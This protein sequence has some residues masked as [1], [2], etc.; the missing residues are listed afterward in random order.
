MWIIEVVPIKKGLPQE[1]LTYFS[2]ER[3]ADGSVVS[4]P[5]RTKNVDAIVLASRDAREEKSAIKS[6]EFS[7]KKITKV[8]E[9]S[10][11]PQSLF[12]TARLAS[13][14]YRVTKGTILDLLI[15]DYSYYGIFPHEDKSKHSTEEIPVQ[16]ER[17]LFQA[18]LDDRISFYRTFIRESFA[19]KES[20]TIVCPTIADCELFSETL[21]KGIADFVTTIHSDIPKK[22]LISTL[23]LLS[24]DTHSFVIICTPSFAS[25]MRSDTTTI[26]LE[27]ESSTAYNTPSVPSY[28]FRVLIEVF[29]RTSGKKFILSDS[30]LRVETLGRHEAHEFTTI[31]P[32]TFRA[33]APIEIDIVPHGIPD[34]LPVRARSEQIP[35]FSNQIRSLISEVVKNK[36]K[37]FAFSLRTGL[38]TVTRCR[39]CG[40]VLHC[41]HCSTP[42][43]LY[44]G[45]KNRVFICNKCKLHTP[46]EQKCTRCASWN[47][48]P[49]GTGTAFV[50]EEIKRLFPEIPV[51]RID[52][53]SAPTKAE[54]RK[55]ASQFKSAS[56]GVLVGT[57]MALFYVSEDITDSVIVSFDTL[58]NIPSYRTN[59][60]IVELF[61][62]IAE[63]TRGRLFVQTKNPDEPI[64]DLVKS[65]NY[66]SW[67]RNELDEREEYHFPPY[68]TIIK[69]M[70]HGKESEKDAARDYLTETLSIFNPDIFEGTFVSKGKKEYAVNAVI[71]PNRDEWSLYALL[72]GKGLSEAI[73][74]TLAKLPESTIVSI[75]PDNLL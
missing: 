71:R 11:V 15:P 33:L 30:L 44:A 55:I 8:K 14:Y 69:I 66:S 46:S 29:A 45:G 47:L 19:K 23:K 2:T 48:S 34:E 27:H 17:L 41:E 10:P 57:E 68:S 70:W 75:N 9:G 74:E 56:S 1:S 58:F 38:A 20:I 67:Y 72:E 24:S 12:E 25:L 26:I 62:S 7:L 13:Q 32:I 22:K 54:A 28:D 21:S 18:P 39:D 61:L 37:I 40:N 52:R 50:E 51:F 36:S 63:R 5:I 43:V 64:L 53:E 4:I 60:R 65:N 3:I 49:L 73:R 16:P 6:G 59:E 35:A 42:L 31:A